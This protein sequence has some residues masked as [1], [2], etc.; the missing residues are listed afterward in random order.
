VS[1]SPTQRKTLRRLGHDRKAVVLLGA[2]GLG[3]GALAEIERA[4]GDH[5]LIKVR[6]RAAER[7]ERDSIVTDICARTGAELVQRIGHV[8]LLYRPNPENPRVRLDD[9]P[10]PPAS[11]S[12]RRHES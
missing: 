9:E 8:A 10:E 6:V 1:L 7:R 11:A 5:E 12:A 3:T 2:G 4:L